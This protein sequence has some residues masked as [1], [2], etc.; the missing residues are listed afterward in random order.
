MQEIHRVLKPGGLLFFTVPFL[1]PLHEVPFDQYRYTPYALERHLTNSGFRNI[2]LEA[3]GGWDASLG[4]M[5]GLWVRRRQMNRYVKAFLSYT[6]MPIVW[7]LY[8]KD[9]R[10]LTDFQESTMITGISGTARKND[11]DK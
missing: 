9:K 2:K 5:L 1:W 4:Q 11:I 8:K 3:M 7:W 10:S 6:L